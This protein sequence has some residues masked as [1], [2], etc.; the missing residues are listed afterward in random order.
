MNNDK[1]SLTALLSALRR[2]NDR[3]G[4]LLVLGVGVVIP[5]LVGVVAALP[6]VLAGGG[7]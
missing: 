7:R 2:D 6:W 1:F 5:A 4:L 3:A